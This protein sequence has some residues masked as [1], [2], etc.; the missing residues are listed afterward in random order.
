MS[1]VIQTSTRR[2]FWGVVV[3]VVLAIALLTA[4]QAEAQ[5]HISP[6][7]GLTPSDLSYWL[8]GCYLL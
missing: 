6:C 1:M 2:L 4:K 8:M 5:V 3:A 7:K